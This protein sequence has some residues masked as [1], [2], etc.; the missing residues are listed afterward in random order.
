MERKTFIRLAESVKQ[1]AKIKNG[2]MKPS[3]MFTCT[4]DACTQIFQVKISKRGTITIPA[5]LRRKMGLFPGSPVVLEFCAE[6]FLIRHPRPGEIPGFK[7]MK[8]PTDESEPY[9]LCVKSDDAQKMIP[10]E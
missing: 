6:G 5:A 1:A 10:H 7:P 2:E 8:G 9:I 4:E 3:R